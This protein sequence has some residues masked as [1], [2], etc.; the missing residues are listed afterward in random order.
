MSIDQANEST[1][2]KPLRLWPG[3]AAAVLLL[4]FRLVLPFTGVGGPPAMFLGG[5]VAGLVIILWWLLFSRARWL[6]RLAVLA[7]MI[8]ALFAT[9][10]FLHESIAAAGQGRCSSSSRFR[11]SASHSWRRRP[12]PAVSRSVPAGRRSRRRFSPRPEASRSCAPAASPAKGI[13]I[14]AGAGRRPPK[15]ACSRRYAT[16][17]RLPHRWRPRNRRQPH[18]PP[19]KRPTRARRPRRPRR[20][21]RRIRSIASRRNGQASADP[22]ATARSGASASPPIGRRRRPP[23]CGAGRSVPGGRPSR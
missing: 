4:L 7:L 23:N 1:A 15:N 14:S 5:L 6:D 9:R 12:Q 19:R 20:L 16:N 22:I 10:P 11:S 18:R 8:V 13:P 3:I 21:R 17:R 2:R